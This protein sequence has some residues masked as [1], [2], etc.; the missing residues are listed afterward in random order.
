MKR[1]QLVSL[2]EHVLKTKR[3]ELLAQPLARIYKEL[4]DSVVTN[5][6]C[7]MSVPFVLSDIVDSLPEVIFVREVDGKQMFYTVSLCSFEQCGKSP[8]EQIL[9]NV[10]LNPGTIRVETVHGEVLWEIPNA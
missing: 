2:I 3:K 4:A 10:V 7:S 6:S 5:L 8:M 1:E 9:D